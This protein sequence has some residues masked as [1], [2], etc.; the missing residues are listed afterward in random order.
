MPAY[1]KSL[2]WPVKGGEWFDA[3]QTFTTTPGRNGWTLLDTSS[4]GAP[5]IAVVNAGGGVTMTLAA[6]DEVEVMNLYQG[7]LLPFDIDELRRIEF[8]A[9]ISAFAALDILVMGLAS[10]RNSTAD[11][12]AANAWF[13]MDGSTSTTL[14]KVETDDGVTDN[15]DVATGIT[16]A[17]VTKKFVIDFSKGVSDVRFFID[18]TRVASGTTFSMA[19]YTAGLQPYFQLQKASGASVPAVTIE[20]VKVTYNRQL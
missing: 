16:L 18:D 3:A 12:V 7:D 17:A 20:G 8:Y 15:D 2:E 14:V 5:T 19:G 11:S 6:D 1:Q 4:A 9:R 10:A 13:R